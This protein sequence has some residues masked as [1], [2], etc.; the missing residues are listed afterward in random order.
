MHIKLRHSI[1]RVMKTVKDSLIFMSVT[2]IKRYSCTFCARVEGEVT[3]L[4]Q[5]VPRITNYRKIEMYLQRIFNW[6]G[7][8]ISTTNRESQT[9]LKLFHAAF[10]PVRE[11]HLISGVKSH[12]KV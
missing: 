6:R 2:W 8:T 3:S 11:N 9:A 1:L 5:V 10:V 12:R 7:S 4:S